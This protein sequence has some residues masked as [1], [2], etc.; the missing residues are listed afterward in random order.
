M[1]DNP[2]RHIAWKQVDIHTPQK[3]AQFLVPGGLLEIGI[4]LC[5]IFHDLQKL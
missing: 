1:T 5:A 4:I 3:E 2:E